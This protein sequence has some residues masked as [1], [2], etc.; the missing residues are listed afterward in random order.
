M[1][2]LGVCKKGA[3]WEETWPPYSRGV[4]E[5]Q[6]QDT[7]E[8]KDIVKFKVWSWCIY[9]REARNTYS[10]LKPSGA[11]C[12]A[13]IFLWNTGASDRN[14][15]AGG[16]WTLYI[17]SFWNPCAIKISICPWILNT[18]AREMPTMKSVLHSYWL[19]GPGG[20]QGIQYWIKPLWTVQI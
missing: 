9:S 4:R 10:L 16:K 8:V 14:L 12:Q 2:T 5:L 1:C 13:A 11:V 6:H 7:C 18:E 19:L 17:S 15:Q 20:K 3:A